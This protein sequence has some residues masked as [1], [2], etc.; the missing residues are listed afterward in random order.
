MERPD[1]QGGRRDLLDRG[2]MSQPNQRLADIVARAV[3][4][5]AHATVRN[6]YSSRSAALG[7]PGR[8]QAG[9]RR[10]RYPTSCKSLQFKGLRCQYLAIV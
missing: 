2:S 6:A 9:P 5:G 10:V 8:S 7:P 1:R 4:C 3:P